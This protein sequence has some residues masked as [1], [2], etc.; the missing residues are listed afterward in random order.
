MTR[1]NRSSATRAAAAVVALFSSVS[2]VL[3]KTQITAPPNKYKIS[4]DVQ[5]GRDAARAR[6]CV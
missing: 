6:R 2:L 1:H 4:E 3:A 5:A